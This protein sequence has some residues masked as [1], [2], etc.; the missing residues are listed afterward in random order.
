M[1]KRNNL[2]WL[3]LLLGLVLSGCHEDPKK[4]D[5]NDSEESVENTLEPWQEGYFDLHH[6]S[7]GRGDASFFV[8]PDGTTML[9]DAGDLDKQ[10][11]EAQVAPLKASNPK[12]DTTFTAAQCISR[13]VKKVMPKSKQP[14]I[15]YAVVSHFHGDHY[16]SLVSLGKGIKINKLIDRNFP[17]YDF[18]LD[19]KKY[20]SEDETFQNYLAFIDSS[21]VQVEALI[22]GSNSQINL[23]HAPNKYQDFSIRNIKSNGTIWTGEEEKTFEYFKAEEMTNFYKGKYNENPLSLAL[24]VSYGSFDYFTGGDNTGLQGYGL[25][26]WF[27]VETPIAKAVGKVEVT[28]LNHHGNRDATNEFFIQTLDPKVVI[29]QSWCSDHPG[30]EVYQRLI[31]R[32]KDAPKRDIFATDILE[33]TKVTYGPWFLKNYKSMHGH[34]VVRVYPGGNEFEVMV[35][36]DGD[37]NLTIKQKFGTYRSK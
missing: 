23:N 22:V 33:E 21:K 14:V 28:T 32:H 25:P 9:F 17:G 30:Q 34:V 2:Y 36:N 4:I 15:D 1:K 18:P 10:A 3:W 8:F 5:I 11:F 31:Y 29:Q 37:M 13:Y 16:K 20:L 26:G 27:D 24:K 7:T 19:L 6:I 12:P 35:L